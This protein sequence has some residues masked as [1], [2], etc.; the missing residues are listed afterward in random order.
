MWRYKML[1]N[2]QV[3][4]K[5][6]FLCIKSQTVTDTQREVMES[7]F[8]HKIS[9]RIRSAL[10]LWLFSNVSFNIVRLLRHFWFKKTWLEFLGGTVD[11]NLLANAWTQSLIHKNS[12][13]CRTTK[14]R[15]PQILIL[16]SRARELQLLSLSGTILK[17]ACLKPVLCNK[18]SH[19][20]EKPMHHS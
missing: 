16:Y 6:T 5:P 4:P 2:R 18:G 19:H 3:S 15:V 13:C 12:T 17:P 1:G 11:G 14:A 8:Q 10:E 20:N 7:E 9:R